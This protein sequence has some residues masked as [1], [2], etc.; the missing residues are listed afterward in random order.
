M[1]N[2]A[3]GMVRASVA[4]VARETGCVGDKIWVENQNTHK[5]IHAEVSGK[6]KVNIGRQ[7]AS[8]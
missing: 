5:M 8:L 2:M 1:V 6:G 7:D 3:A 4:G